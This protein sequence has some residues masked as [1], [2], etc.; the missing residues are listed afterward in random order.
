MSSRRERYYEMN[1]PKHKTKRDP[2]LI[3]K[4]KAEMDCCEICGS[5]FNLEAAHI[6]AKGFGGGKGPDMRENI[7][8]ICGPASMGKGCHGA[9]HRGELSVEA[10]W[11]AAARRERITVEECKLRVRRAMGYNV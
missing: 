6:I 10:L 2:K 4:L 7:T 9:Q 11:Q 5:P 8:V 3:I 1:F